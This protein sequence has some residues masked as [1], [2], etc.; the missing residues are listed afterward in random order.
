MLKTADF[1]AEIAERVSAGKKSAPSDT[2][3]A[4]GFGPNDIIE[5]MFPTDI[6]SPP[7]PQ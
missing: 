3:R 6:L 7:K 5:R 4:A 1:Q 2:Q